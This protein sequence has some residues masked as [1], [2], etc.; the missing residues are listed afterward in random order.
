MKKT[1]IVSSLLA[2]LL[3][4]GI[5]ACTSLDGT[6]NEKSRIS[7]EMR[8]EIEQVGI[9][10]NQGLD[11]ILVDLRKERI[12]L[13][14]EAAAQ[15][16]AQNASSKQLSDMNSYMSVAYNTSKRVV[17]DWYPEAN[18]KEFDAVMANPKIMRYANVNASLQSASAKNEPDPL[19][20]LTPFQKD[21]YN[22]LQGI[23]TEGMTLEHFKTEVLALEKLIEQNAPTVAEAEQLL[24]VTS[25]ARYSAEYWEQ[26]AAKWFTVLSSEIKVIHENGKSIQHTSAIKAANSGGCDCSNYPAFDVP[27]LNYDLDHTVLLPNPNCPNLFYGIANGIAICMECPDG[28]HFNDFL[29]VCDW[30]SSVWGEFFG[31]DIGGGA[32]GVAIGAV[33]GP[34]A[35]IT[36]LG[37]GLTASGGY[38]TSQFFK[39]LF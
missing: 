31:Y 36:G 9:L 32:I 26:N 11:S 39:S 22:R 19:D 1:S 17:K 4:S 14:K 20:M 12:R 15:P 6:D 27:E 21:Y 28:L 5:I 16:V 18:E 7:P 29:D 3:I 37:V 23:Y 2:G 10:H 8:A 35:L 34:G 25:I 33:T 38:A 24:C 30:P 13:F